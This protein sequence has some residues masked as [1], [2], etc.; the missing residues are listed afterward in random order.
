MLTVTRQRDARRDSVANAAQ[1]VLD[2]SERIAFD[3]L[4]L[5]RV[6]WTERA[7]SLA[8]GIALAAIGAAFV[9]CAWLLACGAA[10][11]GLERRISLEAS[12]GTV[13]AVHLTLGAS[14]LLAR[15]RRRPLE[16]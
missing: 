7:R 3:W 6:E 11:V 13:A 8:V 10:V 2:A 5:L 4:E 15:R 14:L 9:L 16:R 1:E 12:L